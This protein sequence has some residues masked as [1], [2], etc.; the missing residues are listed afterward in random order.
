MKWLSYHQNR[1]SFWIRVFGVGISVNDRSIH[2]PLFSERMGITKAANIG[3]Y[4]IKWL[5]R[6]TWNHESIKEFCVEHGFSNTF[7]K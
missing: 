4:S 6:N 2:K 5:P 3:K 1:G 7:L